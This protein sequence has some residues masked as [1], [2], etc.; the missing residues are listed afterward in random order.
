MLE[1]NVYYL[2]QRPDESMLLLTSGRLS[3]PYWVDVYTCLEQNGL[4]WIRQNQ[5]KLR[6]ELYSGLHD[7]LDRGDVNIDKVGKI[8]YLPS[9]HTGSLRYM[10]QNLQDAMVVCHW[11]GYPNLFVTFT[12]NAKWPEIQY[13]IDASG[14]K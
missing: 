12:C 6:T 11:V 8:V 14:V 7:D 1:Y 5:G 3:M 2:F 10:A 13:M 4:N 9:S